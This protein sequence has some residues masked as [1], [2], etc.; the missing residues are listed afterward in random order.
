MVDTQGQE[1]GAKHR[2]WLGLYTLPAHLSIL[3][4]Y[5]RKNFVAFMQYFYGD[6]SCFPEKDNPGKTVLM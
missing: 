2:R 1:Y 5:F 4:N 3:S 6:N